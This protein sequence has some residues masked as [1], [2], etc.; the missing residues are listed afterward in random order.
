M[1]TGTHQKPAQIQAD[2]GKVIEKLSAQITQQAITIAVLQ[3]Q[4]EQL[5]QELQKQKPEMAKS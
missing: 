3:V 4:V 2:A 5:S 1:E